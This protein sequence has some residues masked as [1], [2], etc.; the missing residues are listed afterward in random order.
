MD[1]GP[2]DETATHWVFGYGSLI[3]NPGF[4]HIGTFLGSLK[5]AH[6][7]LSIISHHHRGTIERPGLV[8]GL[9]RG[10]SVR[11][12]V[13]EVKGADWPAVR[14]YLE[15]REQVTQVYRDVMRPVRLDDGRRVTALTFVINERHEQFAGQLSLEQKLAMIRSGV[16]ISGRNIDYVINTAQHLQSLG[17]HDPV[18][19][20]LAQ[21]LANDDQAA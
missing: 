11:G 3:W 7:S 14:A 17:I 18:L 13:F 10:G 5:G 21:R 6:R 20:D 9:R 4:P 2:E 19:M 12:M 15:A 16:G 1:T 8:F